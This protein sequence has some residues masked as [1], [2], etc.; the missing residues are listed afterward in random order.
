MA[1]ALLGSAAVDALEHTNNGEGAA[2]LELGVHNIMLV[3]TDTS[4]VFALHFDTMSHDF[5][6]RIRY[7]D[8]SYSNTRSL[9]DI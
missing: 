9:H 6:M 8:I 4:L 1:A 7:H 3:N 2:G 5:F